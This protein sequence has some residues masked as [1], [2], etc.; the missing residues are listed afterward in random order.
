V[1]GVG[2]GPDGVTGAV[3]ITST[4]VLVGL[5]LLEQATAVKANIT[6]TVIS[7]ITFFIF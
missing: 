3:T 4:I 1:P 7:T 2:V 6:I 5:L